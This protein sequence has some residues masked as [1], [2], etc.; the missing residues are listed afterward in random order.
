MVE[1]ESKIALKHELFL[2]HQGTAFGVYP[3]NERFSE[4][5]TAFIQVKDELFQSVNITYDPTASLE[6][7]GLLSDDPTT[8]KLRDQYYEILNRVLRHN[9]RNKLNIILNASET[10]ADNPEES[11][12]QIRRQTTELLNTV[13]K[14]RKIEQMAIDSP[15]ELARFDVKEAID[16]IVARFES[17]HDLTCHC[18]YSAEELKLDS[19]KRLFQNILEE[20]FEN[21]LLYGDPDS[22]VVEITARP[23]A[24]EKYALNLRIEDNGS[25]IPESELEPLRKEEETQVLHGSGI[26]LWIIKWCVTRLD[27]NIEVDSDNSTVLMDIPDLTA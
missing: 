20:T 2:E 4:D 18:D 12:E 22:P 23:A 13:E 9:L 11:V 21:A 26:G 10:V 8:E 17:H 3:E 15:L 24:K 5:A 6:K 27:G 1:Q 25:G 14:A 7:L 16:E 19:D